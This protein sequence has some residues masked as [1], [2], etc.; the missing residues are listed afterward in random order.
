MSEIVGGFLMPHDP[1]ISAEPDAPPAEQRKAVKDAFA[2]IAS[3]L[4]E[5]DVDTVIVVGDDH[6]TVFGPQCIP[7]YLIGIGDVEGPAE[8][9]LGISRRPIENNEPLA[10]HIMQVGFDNG[11]DWAVSKTLLMDHSTIIPIHY[12]LGEGSKI[13]SIPVYI[14][15]GVMPLISSR[16]AAEV[17]QLIR[18]AVD[19]WSGDERVAILGTG[20]ISHWVGMADMGKVNVE[21]DKK[22]LSFAEAGDIE[23]LIAMEDMDVF[24]ESGNGA[25]EIKNWIVAMAAVPEMKA[26]IIAYEPIPEWV[27]GCG[28]A[29]LKA[30]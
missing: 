7:R 27:C 8:Q 15:S 2:T 4:K 24:H 23:G 12:T 16:R 3:R 18:K 17:G 19:S 26:D 11:I 1:L 20:G 30:A 29:E 5:L 9:W 14:N 6:Y 25:L 13:K 22:V 21:W 10:N 28:F